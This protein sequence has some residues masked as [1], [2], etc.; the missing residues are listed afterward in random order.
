TAEHRGALRTAGSAL[1]LDV[2]PVEVARAGD[3]TE[4]SAAIA[5]TRPDALLVP[6]DP[7]FFR[8]A[9][10]L[11]ELAAQRRTPACYEWREFVEM[12]GL[13]SYGPNYRDLVARVSVFVDKILR[14]T[15]PLDLPVEQPTTLE[16]IVNLKTA[17]A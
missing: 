5:R 6:S 10:T 1:H 9:R 12:G 3:Y 4:A 13:M 15:R 16:L 11:V 14:G 8:D 2:Q 7:G 17:K